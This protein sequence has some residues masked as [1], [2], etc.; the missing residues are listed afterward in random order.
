VK[1]PLHQLAAG[2]PYVG[3]AYSYP[4]KTAYR[5]LDPPVA[6]RRA[7]AAEPKQALYLY[8]HVPF[9]EM[10]CGFCNLF[11]TANPR[12][13]LA[14]AYLK[15]LQRQS[16]RVADALGPA[17]FARM[18]IGGGTPTYLDEPSMETL[19]DLA[20]RDFG[21]DVARTPASVETSPR[22]A[23][24]GKLNILRSRGVSRISSGA[25]RCGA[26]EVTARSRRFC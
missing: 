16:R 26:G 6:V 2:S 8:L 18:A 12:D 25:R 24:A 22:T 7:W 11:T 3:Y 10:R 1:L 9:C 15:A 17:S 14:A 21:V 4:H 19:F 20:E 13:E 5:P 23:A